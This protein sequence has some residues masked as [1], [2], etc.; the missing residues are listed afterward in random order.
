MTE[1]EL[2]HKLSARQQ[3]ALQEAM[4]RYGSYVKTVIYNVL[5]S[6]GTQEDM[7]ELTSDVFYTL[8]EH[9]GGV[10]KGKLKSWLGAVAR[11]RAKS[12][13][14]SSKVTLPMDEDVLELPD[15]SPENKALEQDLKR[16]LLEAV[17]AMPP[18]DK[19]I[20]LRYYYE[21]Q[22]ME[23]IAAAMEIPIGTIKSRLSR[24]RRKLRQVILEQE[25]EE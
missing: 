4:E 19:E 6:R 13:L 12:F 22:T 24:G 11:N 25:A 1:E 10:S 2:H 16:R 3:R 17:R 9:A 14:R 21:Y 5:R 15:A 20:F 8:W 23:Q 7:E 18:L